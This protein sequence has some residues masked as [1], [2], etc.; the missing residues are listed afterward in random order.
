[1]NISSDVSALK[2]VGP[3]FKDS[4]NELGIYTIRDLLLYF[5]RDY[6]NVSSL[7]DCSSESGSCLVEGAVIRIDKDIRTKTGKLISTIVLKTGERNLLCKWFNQPYMKN[8]FKIGEQYKLVGRLNSFNGSQVLLNPKISRGSE[9]E[10]GIMPKYPTVKS[11]T[12][13]MI[14]KLVTQVLSSTT[15]GENLPEYIVRQ[16]EL[17][18][19]DEA[20]RNIHIPGDGEK[21]AQARRRLKFQELFAY[22]LKI[23]MLRKFSK[24]NNKGVSFKIAEELVELRDSLPFELTNCQRKAV[25]EILMDQK[26]SCAMNRLLQGDV[27]S[28]KTIVAMIALFNVIKNGFQGALMVPTEILANQHY[29]EALK[30]MGKFNVNIGLLVGSLSQKAKAKLKEDIKNGTVNL[31]IGTHALI[32]DDVEFSNLGMIVTDEQHRFGVYQRAKL[33]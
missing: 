15:V 3:K 6:E 24:V 27:G 32:E 17:L 25:K 22:S 21:L 1:M 30:L 14:L 33:L 16:Y 20:I 2:G 11:V 10:K 7:S 5:P 19:L 29:S 18:N 12:S 8:S 31:V 4:L 23:L 13:N 9:T 28:G 26:S